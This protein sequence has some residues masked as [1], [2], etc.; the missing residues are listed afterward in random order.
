MLPFTHGFV[1]RTS[2]DIDSE[3]LWASASYTHCS[4]TTR[5]KLEKTSLEVIA[6]HSSD[7]TGLYEMPLP[8]VQR[9]VTLVKT[10]AHLS[11]AH[12]LH[13]ATPLPSERANAASSSDVPRTANPPRVVFGL[14]CPVPSAGGPSSQDCAEWLDSLAHAFE[15]TYGCVADVLEREQDVELGGKE[16]DLVSF[17]KHIKRESGLLHSDS[18]HRNSTD[19]DAQSQMQATRLK[20]DQVRITMVDNIARVVERGEKLDDV[21]QKS[22]GLRISADG[23]RRT[24][25]RLKT[26]LFWQNVRAFLIAL[27]V[28]LIAIVVIFLAACGGVACV[29]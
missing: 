22:D 27:A 18:S 8:D 2:T 5:T 20:M 4:T 29:Q 6:K 9:V 14:I 23:F 26:K 16:I 21:I 11:R 19:A 10:P 12:P 24:A 25:N 1:G 13:D 3:V 28:S 7:P 17:G 15:H